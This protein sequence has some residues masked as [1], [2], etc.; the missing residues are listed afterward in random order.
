[1]STRPAKP[2]G[3]PRLIPYLT[4]SDPERIM[5]FYEKAFGFQPRPD[6]VMRG[7]DGT[8]M[9]AE[10]AFMDTYIM[11]GPQGAFGSPAKTPNALSSHS[12]GLYVY[13]E[14]VDALFKQ[15]EAA[16]ATVAMPVENMFWGDRMCTL[17]D[18]D[19]HSWSFAQNVADFDPS[20]MPA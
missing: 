4:V 3:V 12:V 11:L 8:I 9:H 7:P 13:C 18:P 10:M 20:K 1:M 6:A 5:S 16:G 19:G 2:E 17:V 14:D 15:A